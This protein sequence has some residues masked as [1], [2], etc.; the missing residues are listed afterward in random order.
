MELCYF[1][2]VRGREKDISIFPINAC[3]NVRLKARVQLFS[4]DW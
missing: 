1:V 2:S 4:R 3:T